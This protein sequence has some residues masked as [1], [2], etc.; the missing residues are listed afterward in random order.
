MNAYYAEQTFRPLAYSDFVNDISR[1]GEVTVKIVINFIFTF[2]Y[3]SVIIFLFKI[4]STSNSTEDFH[5]NLNQQF[6]S[7]CT[8][9]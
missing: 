2:L 7:Y 8:M 3:L 4:A 9:N 1:I 5:L 6:A